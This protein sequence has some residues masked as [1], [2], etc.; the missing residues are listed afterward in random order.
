MVVEVMFRRGMEFCGR[1]Y[2]FELDTTSQIPKPGDIIRMVTPTGEKVCNKTRVRV[3]AVKR[4]S[5]KTQGSK[6]CIIPS[7]MDEPSIA[8]K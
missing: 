2:D 5:D 8:K 3:E 6:I 4:E 7:S 1:T